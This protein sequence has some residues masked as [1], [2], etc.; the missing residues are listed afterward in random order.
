MTQ[1]L[2]RGH[3]TIDN[4]FT[5]KRNLSKSQNRSKRKMEKLEAEDIEDDK[6]HDEAAIS[7]EE[8][9]FPMLAAK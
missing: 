6:E 8:G 1:S 4:D 7:D 5:D 9:G 2:V 3:G